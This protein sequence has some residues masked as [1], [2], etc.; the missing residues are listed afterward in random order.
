[1]GSFNTT[2]A[3]S[4]TPIL[5]GQQVRVFFLKINNYPKVQTQNTGLFSNIYQ[6]LNCYPWDN[7][8]VI[9]YPLLGKYADYNHYEFEDPEMSNLVLSIINN[10]YEPNRVKKGRKKEDYNKYHDYMDIETIENMQQLQDMEHSGALRVKSYSDTTL[11][12]KMA[13]HEEIFQQLILSGEVFGVKDYNDR[14]PYTFEQF[15]TH[16]ISKYEKNKTNVELKDYEE[17]IIQK[18]K[19]DLESQIGQTNNKGILITQQYVEEE[20]ERQI[21]SFSFFNQRELFR[22]DG[23]NWQTDTD[24]S[25]N[26]QDNSFYPHIIEA[27]AIGE[28]TKNFFYNKNLEFAPVVSSGQ[29]YDFDNDALYLRKLAGIINSLKSKWDDEESLSI[30]T[31]TTIKQYI[32]L[33]DICNKCE[34]WF[35]GDEK[36]INEYH[37]VVEHLKT[38]KPEF[39]TVGDGSFFDVFCE[40]QYLL[41]QPN[42][43]IFYFKYDLI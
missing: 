13:I 7:F 35:L 11:I 21:K 37:K 29:E 16:Y 36:I 34:D 8:K 42:G 38:N 24:V 26:V 6:G 32:S 15:V 30:E 5:E 19:E 9:G 31:E 33:K 20:I 18:H 25:V 14:T 4:K 3:V 10:I 23:E 12:C 39:F 27:W 2:C 17:E 28:W 22:N 41:N 40:K 43:K 1:M